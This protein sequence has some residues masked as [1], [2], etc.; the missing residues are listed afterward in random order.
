MRE[1]LILKEYLDEKA[2]FYEKPRFIETDPIQIP[3]HFTKKEDIEIS[4]FIA[5]TLAWGQRPM[6]IK[7]SKG[8]KNILE[9][10]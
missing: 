3:R 4:A 7:K 9:V 8:W 6:I 1:L 10:M 2:D 5:S